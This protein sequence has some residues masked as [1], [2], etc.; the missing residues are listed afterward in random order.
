MSNYLNS[1][2]N[3]REN[4]RLEDERTIITDRMGPWSN[5]NLV[6]AWETANGN[7][8]LHENTSK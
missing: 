3:S 8:C 5:Q 1:L 7:P 4:F 2:L 6:L